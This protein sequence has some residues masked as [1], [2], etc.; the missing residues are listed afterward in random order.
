MHSVLFFAKLEDALKYK[1]SICKEYAA[2]DNEVDVDSEEF[3]NDLEFEEDLE[4]FEDGI[5]LSITIKEVDLGSKPDRKGVILRI[6]DE[7]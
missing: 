6:G 1:Q 2:E 5:H 7:C 3:F 4:G